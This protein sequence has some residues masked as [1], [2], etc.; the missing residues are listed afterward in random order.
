MDGILARKTDT[1][2]R[3][4]RRAPHYPAQEAGIAVSSEDGMISCNDQLKLLQYL[5]T[6][7]GKDAPGKELTLSDIEYAADLRELN[8]LLT[9]AMAE[10][11]SRHYSRA[12]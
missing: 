7:E 2:P 5:R 9:Q 6:N 1:R 3:H 10:P 11:R 4:P 8:R 12:S